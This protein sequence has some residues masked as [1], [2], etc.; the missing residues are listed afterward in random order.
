MGRKNALLGLFFGWNFKKLLSYL[1]SALKFVKSKF[2]THI[3]NLIQGLLFLKVRGPLLLKITRIFIKFIKYAVSAGR[4]NTSARLLKH[5]TFWNLMAY[6][7]FVL[8]W[9]TNMILLFCFQESHPQFDFNLFLFLD[10][11]QRGPIRSG[12]LVIICWLVGCLVG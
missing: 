6:Q 12:L 8:L 11:S 10:G 1:K 9:E 5:L 4:C 7:T 3:V 2:L